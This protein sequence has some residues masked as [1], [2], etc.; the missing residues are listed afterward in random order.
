FAAGEND[1]RYI[2]NGLLIQLQNG[3]GKKRMI[4]FVA[5]DGHRLALA[6]GPLEV[7]KE[8][9]G[10]PQVGGPTPEQQVIVPKKAILEIKKALEEGGR[11][12]EKAE[13]RERPELSISKNQ[14]FFRKGALILTSRLME[15]NY[16]NYQQV[17]PVGND[18]KV[19]VHR[20][21]LEGGLR[22]VALLAR[23]KTNAIKFQLEKDQILLSSS[24]PDI[25][26]ANEEIETSFKGEGFATGFNA[27]YLLDVLSAVEGSEATLE[28]KDALSPCLIQEEGFL[29]VIMP[30]R[31]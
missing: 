6:E 23:E 17:I 20:E 31:V 29:S 3:Q 8:Q 4:R 5:T 14:I 7:S 22:R 13:E 21:S 19:T 18:K 12:G 25:G 27:R 2:L 28:F 26:E 24:N 1:A 10:T 15:G 11:D 16:P 30:M 9:D